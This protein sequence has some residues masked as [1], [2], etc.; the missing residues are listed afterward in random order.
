[1]LT[2]AT[3]EFDPASFR[4]RR[5]RVFQ[6]DG[7]TFRAI[8]AQAAD[9]LA[10]LESSGILADLI[11]SDRVVATSRVPVPDDMPS[12][13]DAAAVLEHA[14]VPFISYPYEWPFSALKAAALF[15]LDLHRDLLSKGATLAD[16]SAYNVQFNG[17]RPVFI[18]VLSLRR[19]SE[20]EYWT[21]HQQFLD[22]F[23]NPLLLS[24]RLGVPHNALYRGALEGI[25]TTTLARLLRFRDKLSP[26]ILFNVVLPARLQRLAGRERAGAARAMKRRAFPKTSYLALLGSLRRLVASLEPQTASVWSDYTTTCSYDA[27]ESDA[28]RRFVSTYAAQTK[29]R[30]LL[31]LGCNTGDYAAAALAAGAHSVIGAEADHGAADI[32]FRRAVK[33]KLAFLPLVVDAADPSP[34]QGWLG[35]ERRAFA[36]RAAFDGVLALAVVHHL[37]IGRN[38]PLDQLVSWLVPLAPH[39]VIEFVPK[40]DPQTQ[41]LLRLREDIFGDYTQET[42]EALLRREAKIVA[43]EI[44]SESG[45][46][47]YW[48]DKSMQARGGAT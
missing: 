22:Q 4:D 43:T 2:P 38:L 36:T 21:A 16:A 20:G 28:K 27:G 37:A 9:D 8:S 6:R 3:G 45:R 24:S 11:A 7:R 5:G 40:S 14:H 32:A 26:S 33:E 41:R 31:D 48:F 29:P 44:V 10:W 42:F 18:D 30:L 19:Y 23:L 1:M 13:I 34:S 35:K 47:L 39:G 17:P 12:G 15:P 25:P 46:V